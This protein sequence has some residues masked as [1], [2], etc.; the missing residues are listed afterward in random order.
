VQTE[1]EST[2]SISTGG[3]NR[4]YSILS[5]YILYMLYITSIYISLYIINY[6]VL[7]T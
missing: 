6:F 3:G 7:Y 1:E 5:L 4:I 2:S